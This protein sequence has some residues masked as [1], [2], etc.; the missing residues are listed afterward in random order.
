MAG[1]GIRWASSYSSAA[2]TIVTAHS[3]PAPFRPGGHPDLSAHKA[4]QPSPPPLRNRA[5]LLGGDH[6]AGPLFVSLR[7]RHDFFRYRRRCRQFLSSMPALPVSRCCSHCHFAHYCGDA[8]PHRRHRRRFTRRNT[9]LS[10]RIGFHLD[11]GFSAGTV[12]KIAR[13]LWKASRPGR[14]SS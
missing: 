5:A 1:S 13:G 3:L 6:A 9:R 2:G 8:L 12:Q 7:P 4:V 14:C 10:V 11:F